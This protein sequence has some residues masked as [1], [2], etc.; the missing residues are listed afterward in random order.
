MAGPVLSASEQVHTVGL[1]V[2]SG[3]M[4][5]CACVRVCVCVLVRYAL[6]RYVA[7][8]GTRPVD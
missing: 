6:V 7:T 3:R 8:G 1:C 5:D 4:C 2:C